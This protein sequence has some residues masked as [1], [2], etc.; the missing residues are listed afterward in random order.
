M[1][2]RLR[3]LGL[4]IVVASL[5]VVTVGLSRS[6]EPATNAAE[7]LQATGPLKWYRGNM[8][9]H[10]LWSDGDD[11]LEMIGLWYREHSY[12]FLV[13]TDHNTLANKERWVEVDKS[14]GMRAAFDKLKSR[15]PEGWVE[16][17]MQPD[18]K[19]KEPKLAVR[20][21]RFDEVV[22]KIAEPGKFLLVQGE[23]ITDKFGKL[24][25]HMNA[26]NLRDAVPPLGG[27]SVTEVMQNNV[28]AVIAQRERTKQPMFVHLNHPNYGYGVT[29]EDIAPVRGENFFEVYNG[30]PGVANNGDPNHA[31]CERM[32]DIINTKRLTELDLPLLYGLATDDGH[33]YHNI[34]S[35]SAEPG[36]GW[37][38]VLATE[39]SPASLIE[40][41]ESGRF[42]SSSGVTLEKVE[43]NAKSLTI[44]VRP[45]TGATYTVDFIGTRQNF[46]PKSEPVRDKD[47]NELRA[48]R[49]Y[50]DTIGATLKTVSNLQAGQA[51]SAQYDFTGNE[52][53]V[54]ARIT[55]SR[56]HPNPSTIGEPEQAWTQPMRP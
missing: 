18:E 38:M 29:A 9:T 3:S 26:H 54:R 37:V 2:T 56:K 12:D 34:P 47:G 8:H 16:E 30:H 42:Y 19:T 13:Y 5:I 35:R 41:M 28:N 45:D 23:E 27:E 14:K 46:D 33:D 6:V 21:K 11:Y 7:T 31:S 17:R 36:R 55:S 32:W 43:A 24:P 49:K 50:S 51:T 40:A 39:L 15:F 52:L 4:G 53:Y 22:A 1:Q 10:S 48:T 44:T 20:L 25:I